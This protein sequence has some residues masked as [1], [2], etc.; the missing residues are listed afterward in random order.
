MKKIVAPLFL[1]M[2]LLCVALPVFGATEYESLRLDKEDIENNLS[3]NTTVFRMVYTKQSAKRVDID[4]EAL[5]YMTQ[6]GIRL[7]IETN[8]LTLTATPEAFKTAEWLKAVNSGEPLGVR[9]FIERGDG[10]KVSD[11][12]DEWYYNQIGLSRYGSL[13]WDLSGEIL[14]GGVKASDITKFAAPISIKVKYPVNDSGSSENNLEMRVLNE[15]TEKWDYVGGSVDR[16]QR[17][18]DFK[19]SVPGLYIILSNQ[20]PQQFSDIKGHWAESDI[21]NMI[22]KNVVQVGGDNKFYPNREITRAEF[23]VFLVRTLGLG[24]N[25]Q[26]S[27]NF[28]DVTSDKSY[29]RE[30]LAA[31][32]S[33]IVAGVSADRF[34]PDA[35]I[36]RQEMAVMLDRALKYAKVSVQPNQALINKFADGKQIAAWAKNSVS[37]A[38]AT[39]LIGGRENNSFAPKSFASRAEA[40]VILHRF[41]TATNK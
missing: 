4:E 7:I 16:E 26:G 22:K 10:I 8:N 6:K 25:V 28:K 27:K 29:Y 5:N 30:V 41:L 15:Q 36:T 23:A 12:F 21:Q 13:A 17:L 24:E 38:V 20:K 39:N 2:L 32:N 34:N 31:A 37:V 40:V 18:I 33:G 11:Y 3:G 14:V 1:V 9:L 19:T 35:K